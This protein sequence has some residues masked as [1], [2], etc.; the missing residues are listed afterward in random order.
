MTRFVMKY[1]IIMHNM[2]VY[3][4]YYD[5]DSDLWRKAEGS[6]SRDIF[7]DERGVEKPFICIVRRNE[8]D[9]TSKV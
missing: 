7:L 8:D 4:R 1:S 3:D 9:L 6:M 2:V 5:Y